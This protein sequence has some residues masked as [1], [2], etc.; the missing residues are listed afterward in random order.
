MTS[1]RRRFFVAL[2]PLVFFLAAYSATMAVG[3]A[4]FLTPDG[5]FRLFAFLGSENSA[6][7]DAIGSFPYLFL[8]FGPYLITTIFAFIGIALFRPIA[9]RARL[10]KPN[11][12]SW[13]MWSIA[14]AAFGY[15]LL[16]LNAFDALLP[17]AGT[18]Q[19]NILRRVF[20][21]DHLGLAYFV[22]TY[23]FLPICAAMFMTRF[24]AEKRLS[25]L[26]GLVVATLCFDYL[27]FA[28]YTK[29]HLLV[30]AIML[31]S[32]VIFARMK[33]YWIPVIAGLSFVVFIPAEYVLSGLAKAPTHAVEQNEDG[34]SSAPTLAMPPIITWT[35]RISYIE[36]FVVQSMSFRMA[37]AL[38]YYVAA[39]NDPK[40]RCGIEAHTLRKIVRLPDS[41]C[42]IPTKVFPLMYPSIKWVE[43]YA[44]AAAPITAYG[45]IGLLWSAVV[46]ALSG[47][48]L[49]LLGGF[50]VLGEGPIFVGIG[51]ASC[52]FAY[53]L[54]QLPFVGAF[55]YP[56]GLIFLLIPVAL[57]LLAGCIKPTVATAQ[58]ARPKE[59]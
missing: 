49:G 30:F 56:H 15:C 34:G 58:L 42:V 59:P 29:S 11:A 16:R 41:D 46:M 28:I 27:V 5:K 36:Y 40:E 54:T 12:P 44:P 21:F 8:T 14:A 47:L 24:A 32:A 53:Y 52:T 18:Y 48:A 13:A 2:T 19:Q 57:V 38:P 9:S 20:L 43:G 25:D 31:A 4:Y 45:E 3:A 26:I 35:D 22:A 51:V 23:A 7:A 1:E 50:V 6:A 33:L 39:F 10:L 37:S 17:G 55:T